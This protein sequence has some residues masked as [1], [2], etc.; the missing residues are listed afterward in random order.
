MAGFSLGSGSSRSEL[1]YPTTI[2]VTPSGNMYILDTSSY[3]ILKWTI[4]EPLGYIVAGGRGS[5]STF[6]KMSLAY[7]IY[8][9]SQENIYVSEQNNHRV[10]F[11]TRGN[12]TAGVLVS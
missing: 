12:T 8:I 7:G 1:Y 4:G 3:R 9:D 11:W 10:T 6:D 5:G 2:S